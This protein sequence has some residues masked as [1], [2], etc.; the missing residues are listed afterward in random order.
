MG[1]PEAMAISSTTLSS[2]RSSGSVVF[3]LTRRPPII[4]ETALPPLGERHG[5]VG[6]ADENDR[7][8]ADGDAEEQLRIPKREL[9]RLAVNYDAVATERR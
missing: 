5:F 3:G 1:T 9:R 2:L 8:H 4:S 7:Q 6:A